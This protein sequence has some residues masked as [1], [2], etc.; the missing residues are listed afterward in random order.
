MADAFGGNQ[1][2]APYRI[3]SLSREGFEELSLEL[4]RAGKGW[5]IPFGPE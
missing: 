5:E 3:I 2:R 4:D 1:G